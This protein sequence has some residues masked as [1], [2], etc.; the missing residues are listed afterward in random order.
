MSIPLSTFRSWGTSSP[1]SAPKPPENQH[2]TLDDARAWMKANGLASG[3]PL[4]EPADDRRFVFRTVYYP[5]FLHEPGAFV[6]SSLVQEDTAAHLMTLE[7]YPA[8]PATD[9]SLVAVQA[10]PKPPSGPQRQGER[11]L[12]ALRQIEGGTTLVA[13]RPT[14]LVPQTLWLGGLELQAPEIFR[15][16]LARLPR[17]TG[18]LGGPGAQELA[19][20]ELC[21]VKPQ[22][23]CVEEGIMRSN[24]IA[25]Q[26]GAGPSASAHSALFTTISRCNHACVLVSAVYLMLTCADRCSPNAILRWNS[27]TLVMTLRSVRAIA[28]KE[29]IT[30]AYIDPLLPLSERQR[31]LKALYDF[32]CHCAHCSLP[33][34]ER[35]KSEMNRKMLR[36]WFANPGR[37]KF[38]HWISEMELATART[39]PRDLLKMNTLL[40]AFISEK[41]QAVR[42]PRMELVDTLARIHGALGR[43]DFPKMVKGAIKVWEADAAESAAVRRRIAAYKEW[44]EDPKTFKHWPKS[45]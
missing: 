5:G 20:R 33:A 7:P 26:L 32:V 8:L 22:A 24:G 17:A 42:A 19:V 12:F 18:L 11:G 43:E 41:L 14:L 9:A 16:L 44:A 45:K 1:A 30:I 35:D 31:L 37:T 13:E 39:P 6:T 36:E 10:V 25:V 34:R 21:N 27:A 29:E 2:Q 23:S 4:E 28:A 15:T 3:A 38:K 40:R